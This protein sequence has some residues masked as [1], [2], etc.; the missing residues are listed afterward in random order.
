MGGLWGS[1]PATMEAPEERSRSSLLDRSTR[2]DNLQIDK[3]SGLAWEQMISEIFRNSLN[4]HSLT[5]HR[6]KPSPWHISQSY[7]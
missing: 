6:E 1:V 7:T 3:K 2:S 5:L 4:I